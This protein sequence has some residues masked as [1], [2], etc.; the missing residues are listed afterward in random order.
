MTAHDG[1]MMMFYACY[2]DA[3]TFALARGFRVGIS[4]LGAIAF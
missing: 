1:I 3:V 4:V 2:A